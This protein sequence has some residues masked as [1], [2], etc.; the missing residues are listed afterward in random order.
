MKAAADVAQ[1]AATASFMVKLIWVISIKRVCMPHEIRQT[2]QGGQ[3]GER[4]APST[5]VTT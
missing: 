1:R 4:R 2:N 5:F 3:R